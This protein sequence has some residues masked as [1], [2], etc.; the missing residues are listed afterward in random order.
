MLPSKSVCPATR[1]RWRTH[2]PIKPLLQRLRTGAVIS[3]SWH[4]TGAAGCPQSCLAV[5]QTRCWRTQKSPFW[6]IAER[7]GGGF[8]PA[9]NSSSSSRP[10]WSFGNRK[11]TVN[12]ESYPAKGDDNGDVDTSSA[13]HCRIRRHYLLG[14]RP[15]PQGPLCEGCQDSS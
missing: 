8:G 12:G 5:S 10:T 4:R 2:N 7:A 14:V 15:Q 9:D 6:C 3:S 11:T 13:S 1:C